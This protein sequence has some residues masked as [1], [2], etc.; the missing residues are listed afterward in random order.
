MNIEW[1]KEI[2]T[3]TGQ[4]IKDQMD[5]KQGMLTLRKVACHALFM[6]F[7][8][9]QNL[10]GQKKFQR[11]SLA[12]LIHESPSFRPTAEQTAQIKELIAKMYGPV[13]VFRAWTLLDEGERQEIP[14]PPKPRDFDK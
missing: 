1:D 4:A 8:D 14:P 3:H 10:S 11:A 7:P 12:M 6:S 2:T 5:E 13:V 9:E